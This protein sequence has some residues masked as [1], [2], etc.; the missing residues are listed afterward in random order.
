MRGE[1]EKKGKSKKKRNE[2]EKE[3][4]DWDQNLFFFICA[5]VIFEYIKKTVSSLSRSYPLLFAIKILIVSHFGYLSL[6]PPVAC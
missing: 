4:N 5:V 2:K 1:E 6:S 3:G